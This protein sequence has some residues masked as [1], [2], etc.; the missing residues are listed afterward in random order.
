MSRAIVTVPSSARRG[1]VI[2]IRTLVAHPMETGHRA[3]SDGRRIPRD[4]LRRFSCR[5]NGELIFEA[6]LHAAISANP[7]IAFHTVATASGRLEFTWEGDM[8]FL[9]TESATIQVT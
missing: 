8:G 3:D 1:E 9:K 4:I 7:L 2:E 5:Y 6:E